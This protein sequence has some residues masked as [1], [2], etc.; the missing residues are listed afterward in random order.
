MTKLDR[1]R[2]VARH[3]V[4]EHPA[5]AR[6][7]KKAREKKIV[8]M[9]KNDAAAYLTCSSGAFASRPAVIPTS[10]SESKG[11]VERMP[12]GLPL[13]LPYNRALKMG[14]ISVIT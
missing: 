1:R 11:T 2:R 10:R 13:V 8:E 6:A 12:A 5:R 3:C 14:A 4:I 7:T 9:K